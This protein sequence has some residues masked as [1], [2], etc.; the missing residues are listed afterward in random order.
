MNLR[1]QYVFAKH[2]G[3]RAVRRLL[4]YV[5]TSLMMP[6]SFLFIFFMISPHYVEFAVLGGLLSVTVSSAL[7]ILPDAAH[8]R[9]QQKMHD[10]F[11][12]TRLEPLDYMLGLMSTE[13]I[14]GMPSIILYI[15][16]GLAYHFYTIPLLAL[17]LVIVLLLYFA[18]ASLGYILSFLPRHM[19]ALWSYSGILI[20][21]MTVFAPLYYP[22][23]L[24][25]KPI[26]YAFMLLPSASASVLIQGTF[27]ISPVFQS[28]VIIFLAEVIICFVMAML[29]AKQRPE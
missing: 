26:L 21:I 23:M 15:V 10:L 22:Y 6:I 11:I 14:F 5:L 2:Y 17:T 25:P 29:L 18:V 13:L 20:A 19:R 27:G 16:I 12:A 8:L 3:F 28:I 7:I 1:F 9:L 24:L 4:T